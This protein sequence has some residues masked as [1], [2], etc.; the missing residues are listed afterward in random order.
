PPAASAVPSWVCLPPSRCRAPSLAEVAQRV[1]DAVGPGV[2][3]DRRQ[4]A[5]SDDAVAIEDEERSLAD[6]VAATPNAVD[7]DAEEL[8]LIGLELLEEL[9]VDGHLV[10]AHG[11]PVGRVEG[12]DQRPAAKVRERASGSVLRSWRGKIGLRRISDSRDSMLAAGRAFARRGP[13]RAR[14]AR[15]PRAR[16]VDELESDVR[17]HAE[18]HAELDVEVAERLEQAC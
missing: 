3:A 4:V 8:R 7:G 10:A 17:A 2:D 18:L 9:V 16:S 5:P 14:A 13:G 1:E 6:A 15:T 11:A 12:E